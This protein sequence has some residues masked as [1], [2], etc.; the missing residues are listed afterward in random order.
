MD[1]ARRFLRYVTPGL[2]FAVQALFLFFILDR[3]WTFDLIKDLST[4]AG[5]GA[6][7]GL[8]LTSGGLG[9]LFSVVHHVVHN[10]VDHPLISAVDHTEAVKELMA[11]GCLNIGIESEAVNR[12]TAWLAVTAVWK[13]RLDEEFGSSKIRSANEYATALMDHVHSAGAVRMSALCALVLLFSFIVFP[14]PWGPQVACE[15]PKVLTLVF[16][17]GL[18]LL[19]HW[20]YLLVGSRSER[21]INEVLSDALFLS[22][23]TTVVFVK[24]SKYRWTSSLIMAVL[25]VVVLEGVLTLAFCSRR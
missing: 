9:Y 14:V 20:N 6:A 17:V 21:F 11:K 24:S 2:A 4:K 10:M 12:D 8:F 18:V 23:T 19:H 22:N 7:I 3:C 1:E 13:E 5:A 25:F 15:W 16:G